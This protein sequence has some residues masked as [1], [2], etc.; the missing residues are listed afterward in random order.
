MTANNLALLLQEQY[1][2]SEAEVFFRRALSLLEPLGEQHPHVVACQ[3]SYAQL[4][5]RLRSAP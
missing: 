1:R 5:A 2:D 4:L 3:A